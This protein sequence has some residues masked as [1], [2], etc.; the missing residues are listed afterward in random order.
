[1][2]N[3]KL[4]GEFSWPSF[5]DLLRAY[6]NCRKGKKPSSEQV[7][8]ELHLGENLLKLQREIQQRNY[9]PRPARCFVVPEPKP[10]EIFAGHFRDRVIHHL[11]IS[12]IEPLWE[13]RFSQSSFACRKNKGTFKAIKHLQKLTRKISCGGRKD[14]Y[15]LTLDIK[16]FFVTIHRPTLCALLYGTIPEN[17]TIDFLI[18]QTIAK[19]SRV[20]AKIIKAKD[21]TIFVPKNK[22]WF[23]QKRD[24]GIPIGNLTS[25]FSANV[26]LNGLD[27]YIHHKIK[28]MGYLR[29]VDD[30]LLLHTN[31]DC[32]KN[33]I[34]PLSSWLKN[35]RLQ[36]FQDKK[37]KITNLKEGL[38]YLGYYL[39]IDPTQNK[40][41]LQ[42]YPQNKK[43]WLFIKSIRQF[44]KHDLA[45]IT[46]PHPLSPVL[47]TDRLKQLHPINSRLGALSHAHCYKFKESKLK[48]LYSRYR[49]YSDLPEEVYQHW[50][51]FFIRDDF[52][53]IKLK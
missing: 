43:K 51:E 50:D 23:Y 45:P 10:R 18:K 52:G 37:T 9:H 21:N 42:I 31:P 47:Q 46:R 12:Q 16:S 38:H 36:D 3:R 30:L 6:K 40:E 14:V 19:D 28:P 34:Q 48:K 41:P 26:Y 4:Q 15:V 11:L 39:K 44:E 35:H 22:S 17:P 24:F 8:F 5:D 13:K 27:Q 20:G 1:M 32:L 49:D 33:Q 7:Q 29:Y 2:T 25:Q 53:S